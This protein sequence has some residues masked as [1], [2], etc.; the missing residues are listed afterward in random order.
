MKPLIK[1]F[2]PITIGK[3]ELRNR[4]V[5]SPMGTSFVNQDRFTSVEEGLEQEV[6]EAKSLLDGVTQN[7]S[8]LLATWT[9]KKPRDGF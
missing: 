8:S 9:N 2:S 3:M 6:N 7:S 1:L 5:M 4:I